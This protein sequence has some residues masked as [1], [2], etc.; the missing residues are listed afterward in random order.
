MTHPIMELQ[1]GAQITL[2]GYRM[3]QTKEEAFRQAILK[4]AAKEQEALLDIYTEILTV[5]D[6]IQTLGVLL[7][8]RISR[9]E[10][11]LTPWYVRAYRRIKQWLSTT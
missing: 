5:H 2:G 11:A 7:T 4:P 3:E 6:E 10:E 8:E 1:D 9:L